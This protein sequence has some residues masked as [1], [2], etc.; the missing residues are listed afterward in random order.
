ML[1]DV[2]ESLFEQLDGDVTAASLTF[3]L[4]QLLQQ[5][6]V[7]PNQTLRFTQLLFNAFKAHCKSGT[8]RN[9]RIFCLIIMLK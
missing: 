8:K 2:V 6:R 1:S 3:W 7:L 5:R 4:Q 9:C